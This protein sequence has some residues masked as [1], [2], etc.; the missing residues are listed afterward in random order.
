MKKQQSIE[1][2]KLIEKLATEKK[3]ENNSIDLEAYTNGLEKMWEALHNNKT[4]GPDIPIS[5][6]NSNQSKKTN[7]KNIYYDFKVLP[8]ILCGCSDIILDD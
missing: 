1:K 6:P 2:N 8:C 4:V 3:E 7:N 5:K